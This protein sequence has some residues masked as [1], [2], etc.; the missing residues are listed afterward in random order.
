MDE[1]KQNYKWPWFFWGA[2]VL[3]ITI[4][5]VAVWFH[6]QKISRE[7]DFTAPLPSTAPVR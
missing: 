7:R 6:A 2:V 4:A 3:F 1:P 5:V